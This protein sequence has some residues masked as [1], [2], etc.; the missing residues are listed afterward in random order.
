V[1]CG[2]WTVPS[3][4]SSREGLSL[5]PPS[6]GR[7]RGRWQKTPA[8]PRPVANAKRPMAIL[9]DD[10]VAPYVEALALPAL[11]D[12]GALAAA[13]V[14][15]GNLNYAW[16]CGDG[17]TSVFVKQAPDYIKCLG[18]DF[19][20][21]SARMAVEVGA[22]R[23]LHGVDNARA[24]AILHHDVE[25]CVVVL[26]DLGELP[27]LRDDLLAGR[28]EAGVA[29]DLG[30]FLGDV[31]AKTKDAPAAA[32][33]YLGADDNA[34]MRAITRDYV[35]TKPWD[36]ADATNRDL[37]EAPALKARV[38]GLRADAQILHAAVAARAAFDDHR[39]CLAHGDLHAGSVMVSE[40]RA[41]AIDAEFACRGP[42]G[43]DL[44][45][46]MAG[47]VFAY[48]ASDDARRRAAVKTAL[49][50]VWKGYAARRGADDDGAAET[51][52]AA[53]SFAAC[54]LFRRAVGAASVPDLAD[55][56]TPAAREKAELLVVDV[57]AGLLETPP[58]D[59]AGL[60]A[61]LDSAYDAA[62]MA[63]A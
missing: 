33:A 52:R 57:A 1:R 46:L 34:A 30:T 31:Y 61:W 13:P 22:L 49:E 37:S 8:D 54:E 25:R 29:R 42:S 3:V 50:A 15:G 60:C 27:L 40:T 18:E 17:S 45:L 55:C 41:V 58:D 43:L 11:A 63:G 16:R 19:K 28:I 14:A 38:A 7:T 24:P 6:Q 35:F 5:R 9:T 10:T 56:A 32:F 36:A 51:F 26:E 20:L 23:A 12:A 59:V 21:T 39:D 4:L 47:Y 48:A 2:G 62:M 53:C 44:G